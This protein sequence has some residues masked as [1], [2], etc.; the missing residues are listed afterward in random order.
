ML[1]RIKRFATL[2]NAPN[3]PNVP[4]AEKLVFT[5]IFLYYVTKH[6]LGNVSIFRNGTCWKMLANVSIFRSSTV[7]EKLRFFGVPKLINVSERSEKYGT[8]QILL[9]LIFIRIFQSCVTEY[10]LRNVKVIQN[11]EGMPCM[12]PQIHHGSL[13]E[14]SN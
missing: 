14:Y 11:R 3:V 13:E 7:Q 10:M 5:G 2:P 12:H 9:S 8:L 6:M 4:N 1:Q